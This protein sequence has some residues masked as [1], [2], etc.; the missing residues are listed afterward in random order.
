MAETIPLIENPDGYEA[1]RNAVANIIATE[2][3]NQ[4]ALAIAGGKD[5]DLWALDV[6]VERSHPW[7]SMRGGN[8]TVAPIINV[9][10]ENSTQNDASST[11]TGQNHTSVINVD[12]YGYGISEETATGH[13]SGDK[14]SQQEA[15][16]AGRI[17]RQI[18]MHPKYELLGLGIQVVG[19]RKMTN[20]Q[21]FRP[22]SGEGPIENVAAV[23]LQFSV[24]HEET[25]PFETLE[26]SEGVDITIKYDPDGR[27]IA[28]QTIDF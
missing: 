6:F 23:N 21:S 19:W 2:S 7:E 14:T 22:Q 10:Y 5:P 17:V 11:N 26:A 12:C 16:R 4:Q 15:Q 9:W 24:A 13:T 18:I 20:R 8:G 27:V 25:V 3:V 1:V 28:E